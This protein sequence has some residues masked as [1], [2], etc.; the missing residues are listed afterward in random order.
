[1]AA[2]ARPLDVGA[3]VV[4][5]LPFSQG[6][7]ADQACALKDAGVDAVALY[8]GAATPQRVQDCLDAGLGVMAVTFGNQWS[9]Q[10]TVA[11]VKSWGLP[12]GTTVFLD[13]EGA[14]A[15]KVPPGELMGD[16][17]A[18]ADAVAAAG[19][20]P[21]LYVGVPQPL[22]SDELYQLRVVRYW[23]GQGSVRDRS[24]ALAEPTGCGWCMTQMWPSQTCAGVLVDFSMVGHDYKG[25]AP[26][27][28]F[29]HLVS[30]LRPGQGAQCVAARCLGT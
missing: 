30:P 27:A 20:V 10:A 24:N 9:G 14:G 1:M 3:R 29:A 12:A 23:R 8:I 17:N 18:W 5:S 22:T 4:D 6:G 13:V 15:L 21:G 7:T 16:I 25:R 11:A 28:A 26:S 19:Y 2:A